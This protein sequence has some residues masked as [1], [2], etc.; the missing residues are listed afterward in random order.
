MSGQLRSPGCVSLLPERTSTNL[1][2]AV[3]FFSASQCLS[4][5]VTG[6]NHCQ[7]K[8]TIWIS[9]LKCVYLTVL[10][11]SCS[12]WGLVSW[13]GIEYGPDAPGTWSLSHWL[14]GKS[15][16]FLYNLKDPL[17]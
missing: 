1:E 10:G 3:R 17:G 4:S 12:T 13:P 8:N 7:N 5:F 9:F 14:P 15:L 16:D 11:P 2:A 6:K